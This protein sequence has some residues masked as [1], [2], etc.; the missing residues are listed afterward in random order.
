MPRY[1]EGF[2]ERAVQMMMPPNARSVA[3]RLAETA[4]SR[5]CTIG[6]IES[7]TRVS[8]C[9]PIR[10]TPISGAGKASWPL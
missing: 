10:R 1:S 5:R 9:Q 2:K 6:A 8:L 3:K 4:S 7:A